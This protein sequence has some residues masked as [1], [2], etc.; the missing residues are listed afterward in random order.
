MAEDVGK[1]LKDV[2]A[3]LGWY[4]AALGRDSYEELG[5]KADD[6]LAFLASLKDSQDRLLPVRGLVTSNPALNDY[7]ATRNAL[8]QLSGYVSAVL[9][10]GRGSVDNTH[11]ALRHLDIAQAALR[12]LMDQLGVV[13]GP[14]AGRSAP[15]A[16]KTPARPQPPPTHAAGKADPLPAAGQSAAR[17]ELPPS[18]TP[19]LARH[20]LADRLA[21]G[22]EKSEMVDLAYKLEHNVEH[23]AEGQTTRFAMARRLVEYMDSRGLLPALVAQA[24][25]ERPNHFP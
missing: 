19:S 11:H 6:C 18:P 21:K 22:F 13:A 7:A 2:Q 9:A 3:M 10:E 14:G 15:A 20:E 24:R 25:L 1:I 16:D 8:R 12:Q 4:E 23:L 5:G 17:P